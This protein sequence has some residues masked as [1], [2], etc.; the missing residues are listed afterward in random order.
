MCGKQSDSAIIADKAFQE[1]AFLTTHVGEIS[2]KEGRGGRGGA[3]MLHL[4][5]EWGDVFVCVCE[6]GV[7]TVCG[8]QWLV[9]LSQDLFCN[10]SEKLYNATSAARPEEFNREA[11]KNNNLWVVIGYSNKEGY[12]EGRPIV[13]KK[14]ENAV[15]YLMK[16][17]KKNKAC[18][19]LR[20]QLHII[21]YMLTEL[22]QFRKVHIG[23]A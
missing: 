7:C 21:Q 2:K 22:D 5:Q 16:L 11:K 12:R 17:A 14:A 13:V 10:I 8:G 1:L 23:E 19:L 4:S 15:Y 3:L 9:L 20:S 18:W 6:C